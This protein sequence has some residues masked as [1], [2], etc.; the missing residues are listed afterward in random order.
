MLGGTQAL[1]IDDKR[2]R[3]HPG[4]VKAQSF[5]SRFARLNMGG[6]ITCNYDLLIEYA[7]GTAGF[8]YGVRGQALV[9]RGK[10][11]I[12]PWQ[13]DVVTLNGYLPIAKLHGSI[14]WDRHNC[15]TDGRSAVKG[16][17]LIIPPS[18]E[19][20]TPRIPPA[21]L[22]VSE[23]DSQRIQPHRCVRLC[24]QSI[25]PGSTYSIESIWGKPSISVGCE[26]FP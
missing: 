9:G 2:A 12:F 14:S 5:L 3:T 25:R 7:L 4:V 17:A 22:G 26:Y 18:P 10:N 19:K 13:S 1:M 16:D 11:P 24:L 21:G 8:N 15:Y 6:V 20:N 23:L